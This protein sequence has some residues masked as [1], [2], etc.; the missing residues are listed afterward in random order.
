MG[1]GN[2]HLTIFVIFEIYCG[3]T[4]LICLICTEM[5]AKK[6]FNFIIIHQCT[7]G[8][9]W[10][11]KTITHS[12]SLLQL[13]DVTPLCRERNCEGYLLC[14]RTQHYDPTG[15]QTNSRIEGAIK[16][17]QISPTT[18]SK[19]LNNILISCSWTMHVTCWRLVKLLSS[20]LIHLSKKHNF[21]VEKLMRIYC[22]IMKIP[23]Q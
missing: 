20:L 12:S 7:M 5:N 14:S 3:W 8:D 2:S 22:W 21:L 23:S 11:S 19:Q 17:W 16:K 13:I 4:S 1:K 15:F 9:G 6:I 10:I 18:I